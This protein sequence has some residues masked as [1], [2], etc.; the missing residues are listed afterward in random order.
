MGKCIDIGHNYDGKTVEV[1]LIQ[2]SNIS[3]SI[4]FSY[5]LWPDAIKLS[6]DISNKIICN[7]KYVTY[8]VVSLFTQR[9]WWPSHKEVLGS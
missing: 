1:F 4:E 6:T 7:K 5:L 3:Q 9:S 8:I 2:S